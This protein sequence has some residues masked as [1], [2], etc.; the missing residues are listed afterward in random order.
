MLIIPDKVSLCRRGWMECSG[1]ILAHC[2]LGLLGSSN[3]YASASQCSWDYR[4]A[5]QHLTNFCYFGRDGFSSCWPG[6]SQTPGLKQSAH[7]GLPRFSDLRHESL[8]P[9]F[10][11]SHLFSSA[12]LLMLRSSCPRRL[13]SVRESS[14]VT[15]ARVQWHNIS[16]S[17]PLPPRF[18]QF[19]CLRFLNSWDYMCAPLRLTNFCIF[20]LETRFCHVGQAGLELLTSEGISLCRLVWSAVARSWFTLTST[21][22]VQAI[23]PQSLNRDWFH[24]VGQSGLKFLTSGYPPTS[25]SQSAELQ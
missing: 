12:S 5:P 3:S 2:N 13:T 20:L 9:A 6:Y 8:Y 18:K 25:A 11:N 1:M 21:S 10:P 17:Q 22:Q 19:S 16:S 4:H 23:L 14:S 24:H 15:Q 7:F